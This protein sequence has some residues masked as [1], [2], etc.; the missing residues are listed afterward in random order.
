EA[1][2]PLQGGDL[3]LIQGREEDLDVLRGLQELEIV[4]DH[5]R[6]VN[7]LES[8]RLGLVEATLDPRSS[9]VGQPLSA[10]TLREK[11]GLEP[12]AVWRNGE[13]IRSQ[14]DQLTMQLGD[15]FLLLGPREKLKLLERDPDFLLLTPIS[16]RVIDTSKAPLAAGIMAAVVASEIGRAPCRR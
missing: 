5:Q 13:A 12:V 6:G 7:V 3:L 11:Y 15:A 9:L 2:L 4:R 8:E 10:L 16:Q 1:D 14:L